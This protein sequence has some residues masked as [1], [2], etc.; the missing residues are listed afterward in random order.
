MALGSIELLAY[1]TNLAALFTSYPATVDLF[2]STFAAHYKSY[3]ANAVACSGLGPTV[4]FD[5]KLE[6]RIKEGLAIATA[7]GAAEKWALG[8][9]EF[10]ENGLF[11]AT[12]TVTDTGADG[13]LKS[14]LEALWT[15]NANNIALTFLQ[16][17]QQHAQII[18]TYTKTVQVKDTAVPP[19][20]GCGPS[21]IA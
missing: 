4:V 8:F 13:A 10:W 1:T 6:T 3:S 18:E 2:A 7:A 20:S 11:G 14:S 15:A 16:S 21:P 17:A 5:T 19:P 12:G 9:K